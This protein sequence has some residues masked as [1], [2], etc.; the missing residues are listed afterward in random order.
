MPARSKNR[1]TRSN[2]ESFHSEK[3][4]LGVFRFAL[5]SDEM[6]SRRADLPESQQTTSRLAA[7]VLTML[8]REPMKVMSGPVGVPLDDERVLPYIA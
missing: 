5:Y 2:V 7:V 6:M 4:S 8:D 1:L 3:P